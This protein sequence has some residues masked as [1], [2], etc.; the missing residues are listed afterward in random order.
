[1]CIYIYISK[2][3]YINIYISKC[4][5]VYIYIYISNMYVRV[6]KKKVKLATAVEDDLKAPFSIAITP[7][8][9]EGRNS[10]PWVHT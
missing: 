3:V 8:C 6:Y 1:M 7:K 10:F 4:V 5:Y 2:C 9:S